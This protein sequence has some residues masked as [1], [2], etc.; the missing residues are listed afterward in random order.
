MLMSMSIR[1][2]RSSARSCGR[3]CSN[4]RSS[5]NAAGPVRGLVE[6]DAKRDFSKN[7]RS[8]G[9]GWLYARFDPK[10]ISRDLTGSGSNAIFGG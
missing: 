1:W 2:K 10:W 6:D 9:S 7:L 4:R 5:S 3:S 8:P